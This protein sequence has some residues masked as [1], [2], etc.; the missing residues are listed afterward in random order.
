MQILNILKILKY[1][2]F[3]RSSSSMIEIDNNIFQAYLIQ[4]N[5][6]DSSYI[7][8]YPFDVCDNDYFIDQLGF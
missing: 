2:F 1:F 6:T 7:F 8:S 5:A 3:L 4:I